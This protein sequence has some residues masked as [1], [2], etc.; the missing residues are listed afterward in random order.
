MARYLQFRAGIHDPILAWREAVW[1]YAT[2][3]REQAMEKV[4]GAPS[5]ADL[6]WRVWNGT[7]KDSGPLGL[8]AGHKSTEALDGLKT[9]Y[10]RSQPSNDSLPRVFYAWALSET[11]RKDEARALLTRWPLPGDESN[12][13][14]ESLVFPKFIELRREL[15]IK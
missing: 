8:L 7:V 9:L 15:G 11:G 2:G 13:L 14:F 12:P 4:R 5:V 3:R 1:L 10:Q 6:Q